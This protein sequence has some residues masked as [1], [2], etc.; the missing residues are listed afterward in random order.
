MAV[1]AP[2]ASPTAPA[3][4][5][6]AAI[7]N[8]KTLALVSRFGSVDWLCL[9]HFSGASIFGALLDAERGGRFSIAPVDV[10]G[11][12]QAYL[13]SSNVLRTVLRCRTGVLELLDCMAIVPGDVR[14]QRELAPAHELLRIARCIEGEVQVRAVFQPRPGY[15]CRLPALVHRGRLGW[16]CTLGTTT[17]HLLSSF[18]FEPAGPA[19]L[20]AVERLRQGEQREV[21]LA[22]NENEM[23][24]LMP[25]GPALRERVDE[26]GAWWRGWCNRCTYRGP[27]QDAVRRSAL[28]LK[29]LSHSPSGAVVAAGTTS[30]PEGLSG[31]RN[32]DYRYCWLRDTS[33][34][35][36]SFIDLG[37]ADESTAFLGWLLHATRLT[38]PRLQVVYDVYGESSLH[39]RELPQ[40]RGHHGIG[41]V[42]IGNAAS[43]QLQLDVYGEVLLTAHEFVRRGGRLDR[44]EKALVAGFANTAAAL[45]RKPDQGLWEIRL[46]PR[47][48]THS[49][50]MC[51]TA[52]DCALAL[53]RLIGLPLDAAELEKQRAALREDIDRHGYS[54]DLGSY[55]GRYGGQDADASLL[56]IPR[57]GYLRPGDPR[58][59]GTLRYVERQLAAGPLLHRYRPGPDYDGVAGSENPFMICSFWRVECLARLGHL[60]E[61]HQLFQQ[62]L[63]LGTPTGLY[64]EEANAADGAPRGNFPQAFS[65]TG[66]IAAALALEGV[67]TPA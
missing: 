55:V 38:Q 20:E 40:W 48:N 6:Y 12:E 58:M 9:P 65:H 18:A 13:D 26:A 62:L 22:C 17:A 43:R 8:C 53:D 66:L 11:T 39:E 45:W 32:W 51:W 34:V 64:A 52:I 35:L 46:S 23:S 14:A 59:E 2:S 28:A 36:Q 7:G 54:P 63:A 1:A 61:A 29:L 30:L 50:L 10:T 33:L 49:K 16:Q 42:R 3:I 5:D 24:I 31:E 41:P 27:Y 67:E 56:L 37:H 19:T 47:H 57:L 44:Y 15:A 21:S 60:D 25:L 4:A